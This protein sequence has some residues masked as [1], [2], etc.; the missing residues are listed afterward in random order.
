MVPL[1]YLS[2]IWRIFNMPLINCEISFILTWSANSFIIDAPIATQV[3]TFVITDTKPYVPL[4]IL[5][6]QD[7]AKI[8]KQL[9]GFKRTIN[10]NKYRSKVTVQ[11]RNRYLDFQ[12]TSFQG[13][14]RLFV[15]SF[16]N[17]TGWT[18]YKSYYLPQV[19]IK[20]FNVMID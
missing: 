10:W 9:L 16:E 7:N 11:E 3:P 17:T 15:L 18:S 6:T 8:L 14:N 5:W 19:E 13:V 1:K 12:D 4:V 2:K 20:K